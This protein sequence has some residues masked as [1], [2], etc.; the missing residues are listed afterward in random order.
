MLSKVAINIVSDRRISLMYLT[1]ATITAF[2]SQILSYL[3][4]IRANLT[5]VGQDV[6]IF[7]LFKV[8]H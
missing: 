6:G 1:Q 3:T 4:F 2:T 8:T 7:Y 5:A